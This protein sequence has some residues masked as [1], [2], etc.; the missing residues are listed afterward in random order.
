MRAE[1]VTYPIPPDGRLAELA[2]TG[3]PEA[4]LQ[5]HLG[6]GLGTASLQALLVAEGVLSHTPTLKVSVWDSW[7]NLE[8][9]QRQCGGAMH[10]REPSAASPVCTHAVTASEPDVLVTHLVIERAGVYDLITT[11]LFHGARRPGAAPGSPPRPC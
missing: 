11:G 4:R 1:A 8:S 7:E 10:R 9:S 6:G 3:V 2:C 5:E